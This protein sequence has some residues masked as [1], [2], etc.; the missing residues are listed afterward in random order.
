MTTYL[1]NTRTYDLTGYSIYATL[2]PCPMCAG[3][4]FMTGIRKI[5]YGGDEG[6]SLGHALTR[7]QTDS[8]GSDG[9]CQYHWPVVAAVAPTPFFDELGGAFRRSGRRGFYASDP[10]KKIFEEAD[11]NLRRL[12]IEYAENAPILRQALLRLEKLPSVRS[13]DHDD[14]QGPPPDLRQASP[15]PAPTPSSLQPAKPASLSSTETT[16]PKPPDVRP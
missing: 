10:V 11:Q 4:M 5:L 3:M 15:G 12:K 1:H 7:L 16:R 6:P 13:V 14:Q 8:V 2:E 9:Y